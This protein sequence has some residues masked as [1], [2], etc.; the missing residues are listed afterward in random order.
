M[1]EGKRDILPLYFH[2]IHN[3]LYTQIT[4]DG[5]YR[6]DN[7]KL[8][9]ILTAEELQ[10]DRIAAAIPLSGN[11][12]ILCGEKNGLYKMTG[13][14]AVP[15]QTEIDGELRASGIN[16]ATIT[17]DS[18]LII[19]TI[20]NGIFALDL[21]GKVKW[22]YNIESGIVNESV[23]GLYC[24]RDNNIWAMLDTGIALIHSGAPFRIMVPERG[25]KQIGMIYDIEY[26][27]SLIHI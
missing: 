23:L 11:K 9:T 10:G 1:Y 4:D 26:N 22:H 21:N 3:S 16:R 19:G 25:E 5:Y 6:F 2:N 8:T 7:N 12:A 13:N 27:L 17:Q 20:L 24:D 14:K 15:F 18:L